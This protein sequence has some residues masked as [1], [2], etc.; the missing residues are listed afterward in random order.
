MSN[1]GR[2]VISNLLAHIEQWAYFEH[3]SYKFPPSFQV[4]TLFK[5]KMIGKL[6]QVQ[7]LVCTLSELQLQESLFTFVLNFGCFFCK[8]QSLSTICFLKLYSCFVVALL[9]HFSQWEGWLGMFLLWL[10]SWC[11]YYISVPS[12][13]ISGK[14]YR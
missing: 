4:H 2:L 3:D 7:T 14:T 9:M 1:S 6:L 12:V 5:A 13:S 8:G 11:I 10:K